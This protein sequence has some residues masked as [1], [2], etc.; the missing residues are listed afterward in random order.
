[1]SSRLPRFACGLVLMAVLGGV[2]GADDPKKAY[3]TAEE[4]AADPDFA[5]QGEYTGT[6]VGVQVVALG[7]GEFRT[8]IYRGG[9]PG[10]G[11]NEKEKQEVD[12]DA[13]GVRSLIE[14]LNLKKV[15]R[16][17]PTLGAKPPAGAVVLFDGTK[18]SVE[19]HWKA[20]ARIS[21]DGL[22]MEGCTS[23]DTFQD[24]SL[25]IEFR[26]P[27]MPYARGQGRG[28][29]GIYYQGRYETQML[30]SFGLEGK[31][32]EC[33]GLYSIKAPDLN[34]CLPPLNWQTYDVDFTAARW[35]EGK[36]IANA[37]ITVRLN[38]VVVH[39][40][41]ELPKTTTAA[42][43]SES[44][45]PGP[46]YLQNHGNPVR[47][48]NLWVLPRDAEK[49]ARRPIVP[50]FERF[51]AGTGADPVAGGRLLLGELNCVACHK[52][53]DGLSKLL[54]LK[55]APILDEVG[56]RVQPEYLLD[57]LADPHAAKPG[58][59]MPHL[60]GNLP[61]EERD[62]TVLALVN[63][64]ASTGKVTQQGFDPQAAQRGRRLFHEVGCVACHAPRDEG[65]KVSPKTTVPLAKLNEK[66]T[67]ASLA[68]FLQEPHKV[69]PSGRMPSLALDKNRKEA[70]DLAHYLIGEVN[71]KPRNPNMKFAAYEGNWNMV[72]D[73]STLKPVRSGESAG[74]DLT[75]AGRSNNFGVRFE[76]FLKIETEGDYTFHLGSDDGSLLF[77][78]GRKVVDNDGVHPHSVASGR[79]K[80][81]KGLHPLRVDYIQG[82]GEWTLALEYEGPGIPRQDAGRA[83][84]MTEQGNPKPEPETTG[85]KPRFNYDQTQAA[86]GR[87]L[88]AS[89]G[90]AN[91]HQLK[92]GDQRIE[93]T[94][95]ARPLNQLDPQRGC[96]GTPRELAQAALKNGVQFAAA[97]ERATAAASTH[98]SG[99]LPDYELNPAQMA[100]LTAAL[101]TS[102]PA[103]APTAEQ[104]I[105]HTLTAFNCYACHSRGGIG[106]P[107]R[108]RDPLF[109]TT[110]P[111]MGDEGRIPPRLDG[112]ADKL[113]DNWLKY[114]TQEGAN[115]RPYML[116]RMPKFGGQNVGHLA[117]AFI[118][119]DRRTESTIPA[120]EEPEIRVKA[121]GRHLVGDKALSCIKCHM[122][123]Q[124]KATG[125]QALNLQTMT[126]RLRDD[127]FF[128]YMVNPEAYRPGTRMPTGFPN[129]QATVRDV[130]EGDPGKQL[131]AIWT[132]LKDGDKAGIPE[133][134]IAN[135]IELKPQERPILYRNFI[136]GLSPRGI[137][138]GYPE[139]AHLA[140]DADRL[141]LTLVWHGR[142]MDAGRHW[143]GRGLGF[144]RPLG[145]HILRLEE[146]VPFALLASAEEA[147][148]TQPPKEQSYK[149]LGYELDDAGRPRFRYRTPEFTVE[150]YP[151]AVAK[152][153]H[154]G[155]FRRQLTVTGTTTGKTLYFRAATGRS[156]EKQADGDYLVDDLLHIRLPGD[157]G[158]AFVREAD[159]KKELLVPVDL[160]R[161]KAELTQEI[162]W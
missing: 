65:Q 46:I 57:F 90:C 86:K 2:L 94:L 124:Q 155:T 66:Y 56:K 110:I 98:A 25:H 9:L 150:D 20:G 157:G 112:V 106:G 147:W 55:Q 122:F 121:V 27:Y 40:D 88:F 74:L 119:V 89:L 133:G 13:D 116:T 123:G 23:T 117:A 54:S 68:A 145:D 78:D 100:A 53:E 43:L 4:A 49:E 19:K 45:E 75:V 64:L 158:K 162:L 138:V 142:F 96:L 154:E 159:G 84:V 47:Y 82:G 44:P 87:E 92:Q 71:L 109:K 115:D 125:I 144:Q 131:A 127:W 130:Y 91:C 160:S 140:W 32:N 107:E 60:L 8:V 152:T 83:I 36:K 103:A 5:L 146:T 114:V 24:F 80:L 111:E 51:H 59:T 50:G 132:Y 15:E 135:V 29:S 31:D 48:R 39:Q 33:G 76:G 128:R 11:W 149:F 95:T 3:T 6:N 134:L 79:V 17:S 18:E 126:R 12:E 7:N 137:A 22:L 61:A 63:F 139:K 161:G 151:Q 136:E 102:V 73:F 69:R 14:D 28:N 70:E 41:V 21:P 37:R 99:Q 153:P 35:E 34:L 67:I 143:E 77:L 52:A 38:G 120:L 81:S 105:H 156:I 97:G 101:T 141:S 16:K 72:P 85:E 93:S 104:S 42:V 148:P 30:D 129:G 1:M 118:A 26:L 10:A 62:A 113:N 108:E 58:T